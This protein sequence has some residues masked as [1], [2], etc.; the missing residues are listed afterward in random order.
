[1]AEFYTYEHHR[2]R[3]QANSGNNTRKAKTTATMI[4]KFTNF[5]HREDRDYAYQQVTRVF[6]VPQALLVN[7]DREERRETGDEKER[8]EHEDHQEKAV[9]KASWDL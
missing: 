1:M 6:R 9:S 8:R 4:K 3:R 7:Q 2:A 5:Y